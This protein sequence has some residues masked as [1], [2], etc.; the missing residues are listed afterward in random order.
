M[1]KVQQEWEKMRIEYQ[2]RYAKY[3]KQVKENQNNQTALGQLLESSYVLI[4]VF[5]LSDK[6]VVELEANNYCGLTDRDL[7]DY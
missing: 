1:N 7:E 4:N 6:E 5:G 3:A 2:K